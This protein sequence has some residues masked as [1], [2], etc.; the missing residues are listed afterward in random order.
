MLQLFDKPSIQS[1]NCGRISS[2]SQCASSRPSE[3]GING[4]MQKS[5]SFALLGDD[6]EA[7]SFSKIPSASRE[8]LLYPREPAKLSR[9]HVEHWRFSAAVD[10]ATYVVNEWLPWSLDC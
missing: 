7:K 10:E 8:Y 4:S 9:F 1:R 5:N 6:E 2:G 3:K